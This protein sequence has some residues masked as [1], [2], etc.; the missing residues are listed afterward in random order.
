MTRKPSF[1]EILREYR[2]EQF[3][4]LR[5]A[6]YERRGWNADGLPTLETLR[7]LQIDFPD[8]VALVKNRS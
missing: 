8:V 6:I 4:L 2:E 7:R 3:E 1:Q 5:D